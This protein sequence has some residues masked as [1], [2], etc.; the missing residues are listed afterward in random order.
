MRKGNLNKSWGSLSEEVEPEFGE[1]R[2]WNTVP[3]RKMLLREGWI[4]GM[5]R[6]SELWRPEKGPLG[7]PS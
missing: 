6:P 4:L 5:M 7:L 2:L 3:E 1:S